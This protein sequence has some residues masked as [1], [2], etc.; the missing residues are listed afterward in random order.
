MNSGNIYVLLLTHL[1]PY[2]FRCYLIK[3]KL[4]NPVYME[5]TVPLASE[6]MKR[7]I[8]FREGLN[9]EGQSDKQRQ[10]Y[11]NLSSYHFHYNPN[12]VDLSPC[13]L[14]YG[15]IKQTWGNSA[16]FKEALV[17]EVNKYFK[18]DNTYDP[19]SVAIALRIVV[20]KRVYD[21]LPSAELRQQYIDTHTTS[22]KF[23]LAEQAGVLIPDFYMLANVIHNEASHLTF[24]KRTKVD[25]DHSLLKEK[26]IV[27]SL[28]NSVIRNLIARIFK[29]EGKPLTASNLF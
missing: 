18:K 13:L 2:N 14:V 10:L 6:S 23:E 20:E 29:Y 25:I 17:V 9:K 7:F 12:N 16:K 4:I 8:A 19:Y 22:A 5:N 21:D 27:Y 11:E 24:S 28:Q 3:D 26:S 15:H 1:N